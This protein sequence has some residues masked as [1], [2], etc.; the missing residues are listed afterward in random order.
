VLSPSFEALTGEQIVAS[1]SLATLTEN[2]V[3]IRASSGRSQTIISLSR[4]S[5]VKSVNVNHRHLLVIAVGF[6]V[7]AGAAFSSKH[8]DGA[9][10]PLAIAALAFLIAYFVTRRAYL[11]FVVGSE[12]TESRNGTLAEAGVLTKLIASAQKNPGAP[13]TY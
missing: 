4:L 9:G 3:V 10:T 5:E 13:A 6:G 1:N 12:E 2:C 7:L 8:G 11:I